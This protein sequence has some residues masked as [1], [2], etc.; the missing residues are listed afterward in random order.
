MNK[1][2]RLLLMIGA[3]ACNPGIANG[4]R[5]DAAMKCLQ[6]T[7]ELQAKR[8]GV[9]YKRVSPATLRHDIAKLI[10]WQILPPGRSRIGYYLGRKLPLE[11]PARS[12]VPRKATLTAEQMETLLDAG[13]TYQAIAW[14]AGVS[15]QCVYKTIKSLR[16]ARKAASSRPIID[17]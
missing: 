10:K 12:P 7:M 17:L 9:E 8:V 14:R 4:L 13:E 2:D 5:G 3:I 1:D 15:R 6:D 16:D 11:K